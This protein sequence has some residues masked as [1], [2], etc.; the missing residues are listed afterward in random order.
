MRILSLDHLCSPVSAPPQEARLHQAEGAGAHRQGRGGQKEGGGGG[1]KGGGEEEEGR[2][3]EAGG[4]EEGGG[5]EAGRGGQ[6]GGQ[7][8]PGH[9]LLLSGRALQARRERHGRRPGEHARPSRS[10]VPNRWSLRTHIYFLVTKDETK[11][12]RPLSIP[13]R[14]ELCV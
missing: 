3:E 5:G 12:A 14:I 6:E 11:N 1:P 10:V 9:H 2:G 7:D 13:S 8:P 4:R